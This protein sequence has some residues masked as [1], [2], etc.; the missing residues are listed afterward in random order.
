MKNIF[1]L[2]KKFGWSQTTFIH[3]GAVVVVVTQWLRDR[4]IGRLGDMSS[5]GP[6]DDMGESFGPAPLARLF[7]AAG[8]LRTPFEMKAVR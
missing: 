7:P 4:L 8:V 2:K 3:L 1:G 5:F 6:R